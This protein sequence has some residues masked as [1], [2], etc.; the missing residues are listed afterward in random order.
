MYNLSSDAN[1]LS[2]ASI[3]HRISHIE[4]QAGV[5]GRGAHQPLNRNS[6]ID[7]SWI[8]D[9]TLPT[10]DN[11]LG[12]FDTYQDTSP[13]KRGQPFGRA[14]VNSS[15][16]DESF[17]PSVDGSLMLNKSDLQVSVEAGG[18]QAGTRMRKDDLDEDFDGA[19]SDEESG[20]EEIIDHDAKVA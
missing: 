17:G 13:D 16:A 2:V 6:T 18:A 12:S 10:Y 9:K 11:I 4:G 1:D 19:Q 20:E 7:N 3:G 5:D 14:A 15:A 8:S